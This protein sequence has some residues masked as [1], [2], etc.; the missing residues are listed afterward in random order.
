MRWR[1][2]QHGD[3]RMITK[4]LWLPKTIGKQTRWLECVSYRQSYHVTQGGLHR[5][6]FWQDEV[7]IDDNS[8]SEIFTPSMD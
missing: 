5:V 1:P 2:Y 7:W 8:N 4:F 6:V 3:V